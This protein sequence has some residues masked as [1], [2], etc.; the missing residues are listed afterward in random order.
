M[1][2]AKIT[3]DATKPSGNK[4][5][6]ATATAQVGS[7]QSEQLL[8]ASIPSFAQYLNLCNSINVSKMVKG[9]RRTLGKDDK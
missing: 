5:E 3:T 6:I 1:V 9:N 4:I 2:I 8:D 7:S